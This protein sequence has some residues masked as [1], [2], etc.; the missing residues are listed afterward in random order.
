MHRLYEDVFYCQNVIRL[1]GTRVNVISFS[2]SE[3]CGLA[4]PVPILPHL[5]NAQQQSYLTCTLEVQSWTDTHLRPVK[6]S[7]LVFT[8]PT[9]TQHISCAELHSNKPGKMEKTGRF[10]A[11]RRISNGPGG[12]FPKLKQ[13]GR[14]T[15]Q[16]PHQLQATLPR[17]HAFSWR[18]YHN[19][20]QRLVHSPPEFHTNNSAFYPNSVR[21]CDSRKPTAFLVQY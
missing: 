5:T 20:T 14:E 1:Q 17:S 8:K 19:R 18:G 9:I 10:G 21:P 16:S 12:P 6:D 13:T 3:N 7:A 2:P 11:S 15:Q 4:F